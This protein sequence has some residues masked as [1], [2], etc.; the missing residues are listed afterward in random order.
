M[1]VGSVCTAQH[2]VKGVWMPLNLLLLLYV[3]EEFEGVKLQNNRPS[4]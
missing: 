2:E 3:A 4:I 1:A